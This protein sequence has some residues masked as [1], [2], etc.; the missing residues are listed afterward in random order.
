MRK[1]PV[2]DFRSW[3]W[4]GQSI[5]PHAGGVPLN[6]R[7]FRY[8]Q[9]LFES[10]AI[11]NGKALLLSEHLEL[12]T[13]AS[14]RNGFPFAR[15]LAS[16]LQRFVE[17][18]SLSDGMLR[19]YLTA[20]EGAPASPIRAAG[21]YITWEP[22]H[23]PTEAELEK[24]FRLAVLTKPFLG[25]AWGE[26]SGN[27]AAHLEMLAAARANDVADEG[28]VLDAKG[29]ALSCAM[30][31]LLVWMRAKQGIVLCT[32]PVS[33][34]ARSGAVLGWVKKSVPVM[35]RDFRPADLRKALAMVVTNSRLGVM[36]V[37]SLNG[38]SLR[39]TTLSQAL[40]HSYLESH[41]L[42]RRS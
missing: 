11:R 18:V 13:D 36:P 25:E 37:A 29:Y 38:I 21:C 27:Y 17:S 20:G 35:E 9:H 41:G 39:D 28:I 33:R 6:D 40:A 12:L 1:K 32:P 19:I 26:K 23:F 16:S 7:G 22:V 3:H 15:A 4:N 10:I 14:K 2:P 30:G 31:N 5:L 34:G 8:G 42:L 24:G